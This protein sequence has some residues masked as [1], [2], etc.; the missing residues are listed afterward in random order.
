MSDETL[1]ARLGHGVIA[2]KINGLSAGD[3]DA[4]GGRDPLRTWANADNN[5]LEDIR[6]ARDRVLAL[7][8]ANC[9]PVSNILF[10][11]MQRQLRKLE[12]KAMRRARMRRKRK[13]GWA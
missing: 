4:I 5:P 13:R 6:E 3:I 10:A 9:R 1:E 2:L 11:E 12:R 8:R 7:G